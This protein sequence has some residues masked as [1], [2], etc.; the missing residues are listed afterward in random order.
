MLIEEPVDQ[1]K[2][3]HMIPSQEI[4]QITEIAIQ[5][6]PLLN[7]NVFDQEQPKIQKMS[8]LDSKD[9]V[10]QL[11]NMTK[12]QLMEYVEHTSEE[13][14]EKII[15]IL[16][17]YVDQDKMEEEK[18][19]ETS[20]ADLNYNMNMN[21]NIQGF[22]GQ[23]I[24]PGQ[25]FHPNQMAINNNKMMNYSSQNMPT[26]HVRHAPTQQNYSG[27]GQIY[28]GNIRQQGHIHGSGSMHG[29]YRQNQHQGSMVKF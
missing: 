5:Q 4:Q 28:H 23:N 11:Q 3:H 29:G 1:S 20:V 19:P 25:Q 8:N 10:D 17:L 15:S 14:K 16:N 21:P 18:V 7:L 13:D 26:Q 24:H 22:S 27:P 9:L 12:E 6:K 2:S